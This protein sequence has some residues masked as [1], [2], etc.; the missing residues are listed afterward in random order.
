MGVLSQLRNIQITFE[1]VTM[2]VSW[3][4]ILP[5]FYR[6]EPAGPFGCLVGLRADLIV[7]QMHR[8]ST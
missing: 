2:E 8:A 7:I 4:S 6:L 5:A 1:Q 3:P